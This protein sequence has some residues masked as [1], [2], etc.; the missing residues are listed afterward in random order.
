MKTLEIIGRN[1]YYKKYRTLPR[2]DVRFE[3][4]EDDNGHVFEAI[5]GYLE[6]L[7]KLHANFYLHTCYM[8][9]EGYES[10]A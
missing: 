2:V 9:E 6:E 8:I 3:R 4:I 10:L 7:R 1:G 5:P